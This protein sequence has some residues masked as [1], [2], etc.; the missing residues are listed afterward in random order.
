MKNG[1]TDREQDSGRGGCIVMTLLETV[2]LTNWWV[3]AVFQD[4]SLQV[5]L[6]VC[7]FVCSYISFNAGLSVVSGLPK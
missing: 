6:A 2:Q 5:H 7:L 4:F 3:S 1:E